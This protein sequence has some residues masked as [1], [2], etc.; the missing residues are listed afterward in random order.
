M[1]GGRFDEVVERARC[2]DERAFSDLFRDLQPMLLRYLQAQAP[3][4]G[5]DVSSDVWLEIA[6]GIDRFQGDEQG[7]RGWVFTIA[8]HK[9]VDAIRH[10][11]RRPTVPL[12]T[13]HLD[14]RTVPD[15]A[16][17]YEDSYAAGTLVAA[18]RRL[19][20]DQAEA[21][22]LRVL[23]GLDVAHVGQLLGK[24]PGAVRVLTH[25][26]LRRLSKMLS[27]ERID[28]SVTL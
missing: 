14:I 13:E 4:R 11:T 3:T 22:L 5:E 23:A 6:R 9:L 24:S 8:R 1:L 27:D 7:F 2:G 12:T 19:P 26:G 28:G 16:T 21:I 10:D 15:I 25:R 20:P 18:V 17:A